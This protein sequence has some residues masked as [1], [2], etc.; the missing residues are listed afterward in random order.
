MLAL[1]TEG[2]GDGAPVMV[3]HLGLPTGVGLLLLPLDHEALVLVAVR[4]MREAA[5]LISGVPPEQVSDIAHVA[6]I[7][8]GSPLPK[9]RSLIPTAMV[10]R[11]ASSRAVGVEVLVTLLL[12]R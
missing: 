11:P 9:S 3:R 5:L 7:L 1:A 4:G 2:T 8:K 6:S 10:P 12:Q